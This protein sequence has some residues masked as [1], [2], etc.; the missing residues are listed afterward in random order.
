MKQF[1]LFFFV[2]L[3]FCTF[4]QVQETFDGPDINSINPWR[5]DSTGFY[6][7]DGR[8]VFD[9]SR[10]PQGVHTI[11]LD[12]PYAESMEW[13]FDVYF[14]Y[15][16]TNN[17]NVRIYV[18]ATDKVIDTAFFIQVGHNEGNA[19]LYSWQG[20]SS[21][22]QR[23][24]K[25][26]E[27]ILSKEN[28]H[29]HIKLVLENTSKWILYTRLENET[30]FYKEGEYKASLLG[31][32]QKGVLNIQYRYKAA[33]F[34]NMITSFDNLIISNQLT[35]TPLEPKPEEPNDPAIDPDIL[36]ELLEVEPLTASSIRFVFD[37]TVDIS[38]AVF[39]ISEIGDA[40][41][42]RHIENSEYKKV[43][44]FFEEEMVS[45]RSYTISYRGLKSDTGTRLPD[46]S[47]TYEL[48]EEGT[49]NTDNISPGAVL[50]NEIMARPGDAFGSVEYVE[51]YNTTSKPVSL[52]QWIYKNVTGKK[53]KYLPNI[54]LPAKGYAVMFNETKTMEVA[55]GALAVPITSFPALN[56]DGATL[57]LYTASEVLIDEVTY[58]KATPAKSWERSASGWN[59][60][61]DPRG[62]TPGAANSSQSGSEPEKPVEPENP[63]DPDTPEPP[64]VPETEIVLPGEIILN[65]LLPEPRTGGA[66]YIELHNRTNRN[67]SL[68]G[69]S[70][71]IRRSNDSLDT[72]YSLNSVSNVIVSGGYA[73]LTKNKAGVEAFYSIQAPSE[74]YEVPRLPILANTSSTLVLFRTKDEI[75][76][77]EV[78]YSSKW[79]TSSVKDCKGVS[80]ERINPDRDTQDPANWTSASQASGYGTPGYQNSQYGNPSGG[81]TTGIESPVW[82]EESEQYTISYLLDKPGY[83]CRAFVFNTSGI[84]VAEIM[85]H[86]LLGTSGSL[87]WNGF[88]QKGNRLPAGVYIF[89][90]EAYHSD[91]TVRRFKRAFLIR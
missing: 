40:Y 42:T 43:V 63:D 75:V 57:Q 6:L 2:L 24:I 85:N 14:S 86:E 10:K 39:T 53:S 61:T 80:L 30:Y 67:L 78:S 60:S 15:K 51:L 37:K 84:C 1:I 3:P 29:V 26:R 74:L 83:N 49:G 22:P 47:G 5:T 28:N 82:K 77:D 12:I 9:A 41:L 19:S 33:S 65:E 48:N 35:D 66:E 91:G 38:K 73:L 8:L 88:S 52:N 72:R 69:L 71:A 44:A 56:D 87:I 79:H 45:G 13:L 55:N 64:V 62:G 17:N 90:A 11:K 59:L 76:I 54:V 68:S 81:G 46:Y 36:P 18:Y 70:L 16:P 20:S 31:I 23:I 27:N 21:N 4:S 34:D 89:Y 7:K 32:R 58:D 25:G 50:I